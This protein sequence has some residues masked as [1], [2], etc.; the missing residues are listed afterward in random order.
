MG[1]DFTNEDLVNES[2]V[3]ED[4]IHTIVGNT[5]IAGEEI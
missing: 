1:T 5:M 3:I 4:Y 2:S